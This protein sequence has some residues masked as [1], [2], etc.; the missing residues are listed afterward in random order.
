MNTIG[1]TGK[2]LILEEH[3]ITEI[4]TLEKRELA[5]VG[6]G[7]SIS[8]GLAGV[9]FGASAGYAS[10]AIAGAIWGARVGGFVGL[11]VGALAGIGVVFAT[12]G[13]GGGRS[14]GMFIVRN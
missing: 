3:Q 6:G 8:S 7:G 2:S 11:G 4:R 9:G 13:G 10:N 5:S 12:S 14:R 1:K